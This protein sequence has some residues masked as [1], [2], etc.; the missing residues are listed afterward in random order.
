MLFVELL[1]QHLLTIV[2]SRACQVRK[3][4]WWLA[5]FYAAKNLQTIRMIIYRYQLSG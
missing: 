1:M 4:V 2:Y 3:T 5:I